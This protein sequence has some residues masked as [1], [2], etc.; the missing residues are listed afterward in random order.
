MNALPEPL[1][2]RIRLGA[3]LGELMAGRPKDAPERAYVA[4]RRLYAA[5]SSWDGDGLSAYMWN[6]LVVD[7]GGIGGHYAELLRAMA[8]IAASGETAIAATSSSGA[9]TIGDMLTVIR[10]LQSYEPGAFVRF[11]VGPYTDDEDEDRGDR[12]GAGRCSTTRLW[13][14]LTSKRIIYAGTPFGSFLV[15][16]EKARASKADAIRSEKTLRDAPA[17]RVELSW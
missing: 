13:F 9:Y 1:Q 6:A 5:T 17:C 16:L 7:G 2:H 12:D 4:M 10:E 14:R 8:S 11:F 15:W 3:C